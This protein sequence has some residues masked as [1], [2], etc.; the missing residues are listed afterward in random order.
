MTVPDI[1]VDG[2]QPQLQWH[3]WSASITTNTQAHPQSWYLLITME[4]TTIT[5]N[6]G[7]TT[8]THANVP[9]KWVFPYLF[10][11]SA[12]ITTNLLSTT[13]TS[14]PVLWQPLPTLQWP[15]TPT[16]LT[17]MCS[18]SKVFSSF[19]HPLSTTPIS[20]DDQWPNVS[21][22]MHPLSIFFLSFV[23]YHS[24]IIVDG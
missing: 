14:L 7:I 17:L 19:L 21:A 3:C 16:I 1:N 24:S 4:I 13:M 5:I 12:S 11:P 20:D 9:N 18:P 22:P 8:L 6:D 15:V 23:C 10:T 2:H